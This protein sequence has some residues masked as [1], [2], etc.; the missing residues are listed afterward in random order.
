MASVLKDSFDTDPSRRYKGF[1]WSS[2]AGGLH[3]MTSPDGLHWAHSPNIVV[4]GGD[5]Q[6]MMLD[7]RKKRYVVFVRGGQP[8]GVHYGEDFV[9]WSPRDNHAIERSYPGSP[10]NQMGFVYGDQ[11]LGFVTFFHT[12]TS[13]PFYPRRTSA[14]SRW[15]RLPR[16]ANRFPGIR[17]RSACR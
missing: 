12:D 6:S 1:G 9:H 13:D 8:Q 5:A 15:R 2:L 4:P 16:A 11:Y 10:Y 17:R 7:T 14:G 3:T